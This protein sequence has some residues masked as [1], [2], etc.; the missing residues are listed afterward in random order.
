[1]TYFSM[2]SG[3]ES[4][5]YHVAGIVFKID[6]ALALTFSVQAPN[7]YNAMHRFA[8]VLCMPPVGDPCP[9]FEESGICVHTFAD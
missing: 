1:M 2:W 8:L 6:V 7:R 3:I 4:K 5:K 9:E